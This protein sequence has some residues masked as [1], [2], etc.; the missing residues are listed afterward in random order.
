VSGK[1]ICMFMSIFQSIST[2]AVVQSDQTGEYLTDYIVAKSEP[3]EITPHARGSVQ[4]DDNDDLWGFVGTSWQRRHPG[5][6]FTAGQDVFPA[7]FLG[8]TGLVLTSSSGVT[9]TALSE[10]STAR[11]VIS[12]S[13][14]LPASPAGLW[15]LCGMAS[16][17]SELGASDLLVSITGSAGSAE[18]WRTRGRKLATGYRR[19]LS[20]NGLT[21]AAGA[22]FTL[23]VTPDIVDEATFATKVRFSAV[24]L[25]P[26]A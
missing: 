18:V 8:Q 11:D 25:G 17:P 14:V 24:Y 12:K 15:L 7:P 20:V 21:T 1:Y 9:T 16:W 4:W 2:R 13:I 10:D 23:A 5:Y 6:H 22:T 3:A 19:T 26:V